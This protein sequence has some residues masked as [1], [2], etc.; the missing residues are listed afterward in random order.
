MKGKMMRKMCR[1]RIQRWWRR[2]TAGWRGPDDDRRDDDGE[3]E[4]QGEDDVDL[5][6]ER[7]AQRR[8]LSH[9]GVEPPR[10][11]RPGQRTRPSFP[12]LGRAR[13]FEGVAGGEKS[14]PGT[15]SGVV[16]RN[17]GKTPAYGAGS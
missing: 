5:P 16:E 14:L 9:P 11:R 1:A 3:E 17:I 12:S 10:R 2:R 8:A 7:S 4:L 15:G 13:V 6:D